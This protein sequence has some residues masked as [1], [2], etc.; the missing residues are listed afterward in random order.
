M[1]YTGERLVKCTAQM[2]ILHILGF[3][4]DE[5]QASPLGEHEVS[6]KQLMRLVIP[7]KRLLLRHLNF[8]AAVDKPL[9]VD[10]QLGTLGKRLLKKGKP[11]GVGGE[12]AAHHLAPGGAELELA[13][14]VLK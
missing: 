12:R 4:G 14:Q 5:P 7:L 13:H 10:K 2:K 3:L 6:L 9:A 1:L 11:S 8:R